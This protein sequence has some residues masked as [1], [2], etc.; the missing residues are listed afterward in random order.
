MQ[1]QM[2]LSYILLSVNAFITLFSVHFAETALLPYC[3]RRLPSTL[4]RF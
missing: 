3:R 1:S 4:L 2:F